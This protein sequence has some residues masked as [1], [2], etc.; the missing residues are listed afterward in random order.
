MS[1]QRAINMHTSQISHGYFELPAT[2]G[3]ATTGYTP[4]M[5]R[6][7][8]LSA[9]GVLGRAYW[10]STHP[11]QMFL[12]NATA[13]SAEASIVAV[14]ERG[15]VLD[16]SAAILGASGTLKDTTKIIWETFGA[17][18]GKATTTVVFHVLYNGDPANGAVVT[19][20]DQIGA[21]DQSGIVSFELDQGLYEYT[22]SYTDGEEDHE[23]AG[24]VAVGN[25]TVHVTED[26]YVDEGEGEG[27]GE[28]E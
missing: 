1:D 11:A 13:D 3:K 5:I 10:Y 7:T 27:E 23:T 26:L 20:G 6:L 4:S 15:F 14:T 28:S 22:I 2:S 17:D 8:F 12:T 16:L 18:P 9:S 19:I 21:T 25:E 24:T